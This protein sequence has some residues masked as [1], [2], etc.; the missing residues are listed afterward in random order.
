MEKEYLLG[1]DVGTTS[2]KVAIIDKD[3]NLLGI[4]SSSYRLITPKP[5]YVQIDTEDMWEAYLKCMR[6]LFEGKGI[7]PGKIAGIG[8][9]SLCPGLAAFGEDGEILVDPIIYSDRRS[10]KEAEIILDAVGE[11]KLFEITANKCMSGAH[12]GTS[13]LWIKRNLP[14]IYEKTKYFGHVNTVMA[15]KMTGNY[16]ID[17]SNASYTNLF[18]TAADGLRGCSGRSYQQ[19]DDQDGDSGGNARRDRRSRYT[20][21]HSC[22][23]G[24]G[25]RGCLRVCG[26]HGCPDDLRG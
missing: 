1:V 15:Q 26:D 21:R 4:S 8:I 13:M 19:G 23:R 25:K 10:T 22:G 20:L 6:L 11:K 9:S 16:A 17:Y 7:D 24:K 18:E 3:A 12:S 5:D 2:I 14:D